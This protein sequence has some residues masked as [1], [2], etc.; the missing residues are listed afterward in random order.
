MSTDMLES[1]AAY[2]ARYRA[3]FETY[4]AGCDELTGDHNDYWIDRGW[5]AL[6]SAIRAIERMEESA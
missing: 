6:L 2:C 4:C 1:W 3:S 5:E